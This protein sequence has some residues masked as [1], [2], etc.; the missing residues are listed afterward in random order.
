MTNVTPI[1][2]QEGRRAPN[3]GEA[4]D[5]GKPEEFSSTLCNLF[6]NSYQAG[7]S[8]TQFMIELL[9]RDDY[10]GRTAW[11]YAKDKIFSLWL[12]DF[13]A[14]ETYSVPTNCTR[15]SVL[16]H[17]YRNVDWHQVAAKLSQK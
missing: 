11:M 1:K 10:R 14:H 7:P 3:T 15:Y 8:N 16:R 4:V 12:R 9:S 5:F 13:I 17:F 6:G 2:G